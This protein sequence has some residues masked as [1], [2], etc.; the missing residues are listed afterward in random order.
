MAY[1]IRRAESNPPERKA[2]MN[3]KDK[4]KVSAIRKLRANQKK[5]R[6]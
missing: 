5:R 3:R 2:A 1:N 4:A 6:K